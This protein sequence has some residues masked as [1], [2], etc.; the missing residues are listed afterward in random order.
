[1]ADS[2]TLP[3]ALRDEIVALLSPLVDAARQP[4]GVRMLMQALGRTAELGG[5]DDLRREIERIAALAQQIAALQPRTIDS[6]AGVQ[7]VLELA[8]A[9]FAAIR[10]VEKLAQDP[11]LAAQARDLGRDLVE[12]LLVMHVRARHPKLFRAACLLTLIDPAE[13]APPQAM[14]LEGSRVVRPTWSADRLRRDRIDA[15]LDR[16]LPALVEHYVPN[17]LDTAADAHECARRLFPLL[18]LLVHSL[19]LRCF[20]DRVTVGPSAAPAPAPPGEPNDADHFG[21]DDHGAGGELVEFPQPVPVDLAPYYERVQPRLVVVL[22]GLVSDGVPA[23]ARFALAARVASA[24]H[25]G[26]E[27]GIVVELLGQLALN[28]T[29]DG[30][31]VKLEGEGKLPAFVLGPDGTT[32]APGAE[33][34]A[35]L[36][37]LGIERVAAAGTPAFVWGPGKGTR[38]E[39]GALQISA[40]LRTTARRDA[41]ATL[42]ID[43]KTGA[44]VVAPDDDGFLA[45][46]LP[47]EGL[48]VPFDLGL[49]WSSLTGL[50]LRGSAGLEATIPVRRSVAGVTL[51]SVYLGLHARKGLVA[52]EVS[53][54]ASA[55][56][57]PIRALINRVGIEAHVTFPAQGGNLGVANIDPRVKPPSG[58]GLTIEGGVVEGGGFLSFDDEKGEYAGALYLDFQ[59]TVA[60]TALGLINTRLPAGAPGYSLIVVVTA[61][62]FRPIPLGFGFMLTGI[63]GVLG[64]HRTIHIEALQEAARGQTLDAVLAPKDVIANAAQY[65]GVLGQ[66]FPPAR[67][68]HFFGPLVEITWQQL[69]R[70]KLALILEFG[71]RSRLVVLGRITAILPR[72]DQDLV[73]LQAN[74]VG[75]IDFDR[76]Q[77]WLD[78]VLVDSRL[79]NRFAIT[80]EMRLRMRWDEQPF[81]ALAI[82]GFHPAYAPPPGLESMQRAAIVL[83]DS[84][85]LRLRSEAYF[86]ITS[87]TVQFGSR[88]DLY[89]KEWKFSIS[90]QAG[91]DVLVQFDPFHFVAGLYASL[92]LKAGSRSL[93]KVAFAGELSGPR[94]LRVRGKASFEILWW[95]YSVTFNTTLVSG[96]PPPAPPPVDVA[97]LLRE[98]LARPASWS[99]ALPG[100]RE[101]LV[102]LREESAPG[103]IRVHP[104]STLTVKQNQ[105]PLGVRITNYGDA[106][107]VGGALEFRIRQVRVGTQSAAPVAVRDHF[108]PAQF[109]P[110]SDDERLTSPS[111]ELL[112]AGV[113]I[114]APAAQLGSAVSAAIEYEEIVL[115]TP[116]PKP[117]RRKVPMDADTAGRVARWRAVRRKASSY[118]TRPIP[119]AERS[120]VYKVVAK[121]D[122]ARSAM[123]TEFATRTE[124]LDAFARLPA[125]QQAQLQIVSRWR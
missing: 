120:R 62:K 1:M 7:R 9:L 15:L 50:A 27:R 76:R 112:E 78:A 24:R 81:F 26:G 17:R 25:P 72:P 115:P 80:G 66:F 119:H 33:G 70:L 88:V 108:A 16:P 99:A 31:R 61:E 111:F 22:P 55:S 20:E 105:V 79:A 12:Q 67:D 32:L 97:A 93:F 29:R 38:L 37:R 104:S 83:A 117:N 58:V 21:D 109:R 107:V 46:L 3:G 57:G 49:V 84:E 124:A 90:G 28:E 122:L 86:A 114:G 85:N 40:E 30:W 69:I 125:S 19:G 23:P 14:V 87:N 53:I 2:A 121:D 44:L 102:S 13:V 18:R 51:D 36:A 42:A 8:D 73:R 118:Q 100:A 4:A 10:G 54:S 71:E 47:P 92:Q 96:E 89:A 45:S 123:P 68:H 39:V 65:L 116:E 91:Y 48:R 103:Q 77:A 98:A 82:G 41:M 5:R 94:P 43:A 64:V 11:A 74:V 56:I 75:G 34:S 110:M 60:V 59:G 63:G 101:R 6:W 113:A 35:A 95:D 106:K 52:G